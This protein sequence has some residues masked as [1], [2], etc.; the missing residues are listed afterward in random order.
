MAVTGW[1]LC[2]YG[3][4]LCHA[5]SPG[6]RAALEAVAGLPGA[7]LWSRYWQHRRDYDGGGSPQEYWTAVLGRP[8]P[9]PQLDEL[10][11]ADLA[12]WLHPNEGALAAAAR[13]ARRGWRLAVL[14]NAPAHQAAAFDAAAWLQPFSPRLFSGRLG[15]TKP[16]TAAFRAALRALR[17][18]PGAVVFV[19]DRAP[20]VQAA[21]ALGLTAVRFE[22]PE[23]IDEATASSPGR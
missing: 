6:D 17:A 13:A 1:L 19:D 21:A 10:L 2:D 3:E 9:Q 23:Q 7:V 22:R 4:V 8:V 11:A 16:D 5:P 20:N 18:E 15:V 12:G 14:S